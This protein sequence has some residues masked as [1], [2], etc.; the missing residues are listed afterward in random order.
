FLLE[1]GSEELPATF[2]PSG[3]ASLERNMRHFL[4]AHNL[5]YEKIETYGTPRRLAIMIKN[6]SAGTPSH[7]LEKKGPPLA[8]AFDE[9]GQTTQAGHS[10]LKVAGYGDIKLSQIK[11]KEIEGLEIR[12]IKN[13]PYLFAKIT[14][15]EL[16]TRRLLAENL[17]QLILNIEFPKKMRWGAFDIEYARPLRWLVSL[18]GSEEIPFALGPLLAGRTSCGHRQL[19]PKAFVIG[20]AKEYLELL[21]KAHVMANVTERRRSIL[22]QLEECEKKQGMFAVAKEKV[23]PQVLHLV[24]WPFLTVGTFNTQ[25]LRAPKEVLISEMIEHQKYFPLMDSNGE[26]TPT[27][28]IICNNRPTDLIRAGNQKALS[29]RLADGLF[30]YDEDLKTALDTFCEKLKTV[31]Y[32][33][34]LGSL[35]TKT[36]RLI[37][38]AALMHSLLPIAD[39]DKL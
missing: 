12:E 7:V 34:D 22:D 8:T 32:Q 11:R 6:L 24:E 1:I 28:A 10:F 30:L 38:L 39:L 3:M 15:P 31:T 27:F 5:S 2:V 23:L 35:W 37:G 33:K 18:Y 19:S 9:K 14:I 13:V 21:R 26:I 20:E 36:E 29:P 4:E 25:Y 16:S 17:P